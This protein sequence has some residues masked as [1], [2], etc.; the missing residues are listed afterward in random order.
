MIG[1]IT[2]TQMVDLNYNTAKAE[3]T[4]IK[5]PTKVPVTRSPD[6]SH[7]EMDSKL[8]TKV[9][10]APAIEWDEATKAKQTELDNYIRMK[11]PSAVF[12]TNCELEESDFW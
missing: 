8:T 6:I 4:N 5:L 10:E 3:N 7:G 1:T 2:H 12:I 9:L 11:Y